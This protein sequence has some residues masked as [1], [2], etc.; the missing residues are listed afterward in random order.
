MRELKQLMEAEDDGDFYEIASED[1]IDADAPPHL[2]PS[3]EG[4]Q[5][6]EMEAPDEAGDEHGRVEARAAAIRDAA[7]KAHV[8]DDVPVPIK[9]FRAQQ[10]FQAQQQFYV[11]KVLTEKGREKQLD[12]E[13]PWHMIPPEEREE[14]Q[15]AELKQWQEHLDFEAVRPLSVDESLE[16]E[17]TVDP[18]VD[19]SVKLKAEA[20]LCVAGQH[21]PDLGAID[22]VTDAPTT[23]RHALLL[24]SQLSLARRWTASVG[25]ARA[26]FLN[27]LPAPRQLYF[28]QPRRGMPTL[29]K[30]QLI[31]IIKG[32]FG[33]STSPKLWWMKLSSELCQ[34]ELNYE[35]EV[36]KVKQNYIDPCVFMIVNPA[37]GTRGLVLTHVD[38]LMLL[39]EPGLDV[40]I[41]QELSRKFPFDEWEN[42]VFE[43]LG[44]EYE[45]KPDEILIKQQSYTQSPGGKG[46]LGSGHGG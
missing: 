25:D 45:C 9:R 19:P 30:G 5:N 40:Q 20:R 36:L 33:L 13:L 43:Y 46:H 35:G 29:E 10:P 38:D 37:G 24:A 28:R 32:V 26:A 23:S 11:K 4:G 44:C 14:H 8:L 18:K 39:T 6:V 27:G 31:E 42:K 16:V 21:D 2:Q 22:M 7:R 15:A 1:D 3:Y 17:K 34:L 12:K 41:Q